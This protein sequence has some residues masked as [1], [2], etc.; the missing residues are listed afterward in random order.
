VEEIPCVDTREIEAGVN[1]KVS[2]TE[3]RK[4]ISKK[5]TNNKNQTNN[6]KR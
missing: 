2:A 3:R 6:K 4:G 1:R 5:L